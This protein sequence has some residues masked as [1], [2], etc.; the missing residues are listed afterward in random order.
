M[1]ALVG[2]A[3]VFMGCMALMTSLELRRAGPRCV[4]CGR[5]RDPRGV[6]RCRRC[7]RKE[8]RR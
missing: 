7:E 6:T 2:A 3:V 1:M 4:A 5:H 8:K